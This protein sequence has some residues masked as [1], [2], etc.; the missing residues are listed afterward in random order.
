MGRRRIGAYILPGDATWL[1]KSLVQY[2]PLLDAL[3]IP[4]PHGDVGWTGVGV[5]VAGVMAKVRKMDVRGLA[6]TVHGSWVNP[7]EPMRA[8]TAQRQTALDALAGDVDWVIQMDNDEYMPEPQALLAAIDEAEKRGLDAVEWPMRVLYRRT[9]SH[10]FEIV[11]SGGEARYDW[12][13]AVALRPHLTLTDARRVVGPYLR[14]TVAGDDVS[15]QL[16]HPTENGEV[17][18]AG[19][20]AEQAIIHNSWAR[21]PRQIRQKTRSWGHAAGLRGIV[22]YAATW[23]PSPLTWWAIRDLHPFARGLWPRLN[24]RPIAQEER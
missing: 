5:D 21:S 17:R 11:G 15:L 22:Y 13:G 9:R 18:W 12:P 4:V 8:D 6:E 2:Y 10:M 24:R 23:L 20:A 3:V 14:V 1:E 16:R 7:D 19:I